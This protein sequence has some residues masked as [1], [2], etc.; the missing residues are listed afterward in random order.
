MSIGVNEVT[1]IGFLGDKPEIRVTQNRSKIA[2][3]N[4]ATTESW[5]D[6]KNGEKKQVTEWHRV[7]VM[8][9][10]LAC[11]VEQLAAKGSLVYVKGKIRKKKWEYQGV[12]RTATDILAREFTLL[13][14]SK[15]AKALEVV[16]KVSFPEVSVDLGAG[17]DAN[18][19]SDSV[20]N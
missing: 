4:M 2:N 10:K 16:K 13:G 6:K 3:F 8:D 20:S 1:L 14:G 5:K 19:V 18:S 17:G 7:V 15:E 11:I 12:E 9:N